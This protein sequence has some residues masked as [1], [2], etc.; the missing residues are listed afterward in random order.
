MQKRVSQDKLTV[1]SAGGLGSERESIRAKE[2][3]DLLRNV[4]QVGVLVAVFA[5]VLRRHLG[6]LTFV[7]VRQVRLQ[8]GER[9]G[10]GGRHRLFGCLAH[11]VSACQRS[12]PR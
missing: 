7:D 1:S 6:R 3:I 11:L 5:T 8:L 12:S 2:W 9:S 10:E 4:C